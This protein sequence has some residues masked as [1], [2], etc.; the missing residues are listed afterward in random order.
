MPQPLPTNQSWPRNTLRDARIN[1][2]CACLTAIR[3]QGSATQRACRCLRACASNPHLLRAANRTRPQRTADH[4]PAELTAVRGTT[5]LN[6]ANAGVSSAAQL[7]RGAQTAL[8]LQ[9]AWAARERYPAP[10]SPR[11]SSRAERT[12]PWVA[13]T[14]RGR[15]QLRESEEGARSGDWGNG[16]PR[17]VQFNCRYRCS[18]CLCCPH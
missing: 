6:R 9:S 11:A 17:G 18:A 7:E 5:S 10:T 1:L 12:Q 14:P 8:S 3:A 15:S 2:E 16:A 13:N 4:Q